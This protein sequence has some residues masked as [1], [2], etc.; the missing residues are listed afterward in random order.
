MM[1]LFKT[2][3][4]GNTFLH[5]AR[6]LTDNLDIGEFTKHNCSSEDG[7]SSDGLVVYEKLL[8]YVKFEIYNK[9]GSRAEISGNG[10]AGLSA[11]LFYTNSFE[12]TVKIH[13]SCGIKTTELID[14][15]SDNVFL[16]KIEIGNPN[17]HSLGDFPM[18][19]PDKMEYKY[20]N[21]SF[22]PV[23]LGN[24]HIVILFPKEPD[25]KFLES[26]GQELSNADIFPNKTNVEFVWD[27]Q[28]NS[29]SVFFFERGVGRTKTSATGSA[30]VYAILSSLNLISPRI[31][32]SNCQQSFFISKKKS[33]Y[34]ENYTKILYKITLL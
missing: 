8:D 4:S 11:L 23:S 29:C 16:L 31:T 28:K 7:L 6:N 19:L 24:P 18:L 14:R 12:K 22:H 20:K 27:I 32:I 34:I 13:T 21:I 5:L 1:E 3:S 2:I 9:D 15:P 10:M 26:L 17:F 25:F 30:A 33:I